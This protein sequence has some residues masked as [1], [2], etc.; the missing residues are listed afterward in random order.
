MDF[1]EALEAVWEKG[2]HRGPDVIGERQCDEDL[3]KE[4]GRSE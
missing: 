4:K 2:R 1:E 3:R